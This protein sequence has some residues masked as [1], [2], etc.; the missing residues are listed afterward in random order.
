MAAV[1]NPIVQTTQI[2]AAP[3]G[4]DPGLDNGIPPSVPVDPNTEADLPE[5]PAPTDHARE[6]M[7]KNR[8]LIF[9]QQ[10]DRIIGL[11]PMPEATNALE[12]LQLGSLKKWMTLTGIQKKLQGTRA[13]KKLSLLLKPDTLGLLDPEEKEKASIAFKSKQLSWFENT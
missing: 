3:G 10:L 1:E 13:H 2:P 9:H 7:E 8:R 12:V 11:G 5:E 6:Q 4:I